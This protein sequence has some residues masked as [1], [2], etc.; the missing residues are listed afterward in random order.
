MSDLKASVMSSYQGVLNIVYA[1]GNSR[2]GKGTI[3]SAAC[4]VEGVRTIIR[5]LSLGYLHS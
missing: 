1:L 5:D 4:E 2:S 3:C